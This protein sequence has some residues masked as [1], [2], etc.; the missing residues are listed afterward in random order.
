MVRLRPLSVPRAPFADHEEFPRLVHAAFGQR[1][2]MLRNNLGRHVAARFG[3]DALVGVLEG[4]GLRGDVRPE[5]LSVA[6][7]AALTREVVR[8]RDAQ[9]GAARPAADGAA[10]VAAEPTRQDADATTTGDAAAASIR[11]EGAATRA[12]A[13]APKDAGHA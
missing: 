13:A 1:R 7:F 3:E 10:N 9:A 5:E 4:A 2:K 12:P 8:L 6:D 11:E